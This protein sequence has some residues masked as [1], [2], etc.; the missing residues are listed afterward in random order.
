MRRAKFTINQENDIIAVVNGLK[1]IMNNCL[2]IIDE[3]ENVEDAIEDQLKNLGKQNTQDTK[4]QGWF[5]WWGTKQE[6]GP[7]DPNQLINNSIFLQMQNIIL[8]CLNIWGDLDL[9]RVRDFHFTRMGVFPY[10]KEDDKRMDHLIMGKI[11]VDLNVT[12]QKSDPR[13]LTQKN[14]Q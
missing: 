9:Y 3:F 8:S 12:K 14:Q 6:T 1:S 7:A 13:I 2:G 11:P 4:G 10:H 5:N